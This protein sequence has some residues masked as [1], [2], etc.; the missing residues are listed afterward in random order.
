MGAAYN[1]TP[2]Y[3]KDAVLHRPSQSLQKADILDPAGVNDSDK[4]DRLKPTLTIAFPFAA[5]DPDPGAEKRY[6]DRAILSMLQDATSGETEP[7]RMVNKRL[8][9]PEESAPLVD[10]IRIDKPFVIRLLGDKA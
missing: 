10:S 3:T 2:A 4:N 6:V 7:V 5:L 9:R 1:M 8:F